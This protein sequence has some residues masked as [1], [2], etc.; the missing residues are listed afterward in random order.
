MNHRPR[1]VALFGD[2]CTSTNEPIAMTAKYWH[3]VQLSYA[4]THPKFAGADSKS[5]YPSFFR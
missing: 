5:L 2:A 4:E 1:S 3:V